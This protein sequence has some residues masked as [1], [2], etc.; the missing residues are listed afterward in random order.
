MWGTWGK[1]VCDFVPSLHVKL[2]CGD[3]VFFRISYC[4][5]GLILNSQLMLGFY[6]LN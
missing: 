6:L 3:V 5:V 4:T 2:L 1:D